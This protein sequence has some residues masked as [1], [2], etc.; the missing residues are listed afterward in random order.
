MARGCFLSGIG[1]RQQVESNGGCVPL[2]FRLP[3]PCSLLPTH[4]DAHFRFNPQ[5][6]DCD[7]RRVCAAIV[8]TLPCAQCKGTC[9]TGHRGVLLDDG[10]ILPFI[11]NRCPH[12]DAAGRCG[13]YDTRPQ[14][15]R[16]F[17]CSR[18]PGFRR[19]NP[20]VAALL[21]IHGIPLAPADT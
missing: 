21:S 5:L 16:D 9:C 7:G 18:E 20:H 15:C 12:L 10:T 13:I 4:C 19:T 14:G 1:N 6:Q 2:L 17:D 11:D 8:V 3:I